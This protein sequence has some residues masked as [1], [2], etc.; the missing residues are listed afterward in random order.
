MTAGNVACTVCGCVCDDLRVTVAGGR[1][2]RADGAC[3]LAEPWFLS[4]NA[5]RPP[6]AEVGGLP[7]DPDAAFARAAD[8][9][10]A[11]KYP[12]I[13]GLSRSTTEG[14]RAAVALADRLGATIDTTASTGHAPSL[15][16]LQQVGESTSTL[17]EVRNRADLVVFWGSDPV[18]THPRHLE[19]YSLEP[20]GR[21]VPGGRAD[22]LLVV[23]DE[24]E[25]ETARLAD[26]FVRVPPGG[27]WEAL[28]EL[29]LLVRAGSVSDGSSRTVAH[30]SGSDGLADLARRMKGCRCG[31][32]FF[33][34]GVTAGKLAHR[35]VEALLRLVT[36]LNE[37]TRF[38]ARRMRRY[39]DVAGA[40][41]VLAWQTGY[42]FG[43][44]LSRGYPRY[45]PG[46]FTGPEILARGEA[47]A[48][49]VV[50]GETAADFPPAALEHLRRIPV[51]LLDPPGAAAVVPAAVRFATAVYGVHRPGTAYRM[52]EVPV[53]LRVILPTDYPSDAE[54]LNELLRRVG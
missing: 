34:S 3:R 4:Q 53:P 33:G 44:N 2:V 22:R 46:E 20:R 21:W 10:R 9:L 12:L 32:I 18:V 48:C 30:A 28:W 41:S 5:S 52:D 47:D 39:G 50:G 11:A 31:V 26:L 40:D 16:A 13:Y 25:T 19:R 35:T 6:A 1:V 15:V 27:H 7:A 24:H 8:L 36:D 45:N 49:L 23:V 51:V 37:H 54:V 38:Y 17:G 42:P 43:V 29:R 14:Q